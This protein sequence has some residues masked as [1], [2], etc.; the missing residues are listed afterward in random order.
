[1]KALSQCPRQGLPIDLHV[2]SASVVNDHAV[3]HCTLYSMTTETSWSVAYR[4]SE[5]HAFKRT[6]EKVLTC[7]SPKCSGS[8]QAIRDYM[9]A[10]FP[11]KHA[12]FSTSQRTRKDRQLKL[13]NVLLHLLRCVLLPGSAMKCASARR[14]LPPHLFEFLG[15]QHALDRRSL[16]QIYVDNYQRVLKHSPFSRP[17]ASSASSSRSSEADAET[18]TSCCRCMICLEDVDENATAVADSQDG[19]DDDSHHRCNHSRSSS[20]CCRTSCLSD[21]EVPLPVSP[22]VLCADTARHKAQLATT[23]S[24][25]AM[26]AV[27]LPCTH[28]FHRECVFEWLLFEFHCPLCRSR[29]GPAATTNFCRAKNRVQWWIGELESGPLRRESTA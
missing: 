28:V 29:V 19:E 3:Y 26:A 24:T 5:L 27:A 18:E 9:N 7:D 6:V 20:S 14:A 17:S 25:V 15:V 23:T 1:M 10:C 16:L 22:S 11:K 8:C 21:E 12:L 2:A 4:Y 13:E